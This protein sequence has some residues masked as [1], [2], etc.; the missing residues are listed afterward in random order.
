MREGI[1]DNSKIFLNEK[2]YCNPHQ[3]GS[4]DGSQYKHIL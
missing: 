4:D 1:A 2:I 3:N